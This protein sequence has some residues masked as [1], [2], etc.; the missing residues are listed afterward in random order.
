VKILQLLPLFVQVEALKGRL[1][2]GDEALLYEVATAAVREYESFRPKYLD[3]I[4]PYS[5]ASE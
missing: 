1:L 3:Y 2:F 5:E 4:R